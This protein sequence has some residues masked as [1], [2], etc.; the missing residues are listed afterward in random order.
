MG[1]RL[2]GR[3]D[4]PGFHPP[5]VDGVEPGMDLHLPHPVP[6]GAAAQPVG[7]RFLEET[8]AQ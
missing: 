4:A 7:G 2:E 6:A 5:P 8:L 1:V 3:G